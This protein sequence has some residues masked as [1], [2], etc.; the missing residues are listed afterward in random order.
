VSDEI[1]VLDRADPPPFDILGAEPS[2]PVLLV[3][4]H[5]SS[6]IPARFHNLGVSDEIMKTHCALDIGAAAVTRLLSRSLALPAVLAGYSRLVVDCNRRLDD[7][8]AFPASIDGFVIPGNQEMTHAERQ[9]RADAL[10]WPYHHAVRD[11]L[12]MLE[13][14]AKAPALV[15]IHSFVPIRNG[16]H[17]PWDIG[18]LWDVD[19]R[20]PVP[21][22]EGMRKYPEIAVGDNEPYSGKHIHDFTVDHHAE[23]EGLPHVSIELRQDLIDNDEGAGHWAELLARELRPILSDAALYTHW[24]T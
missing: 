18:V 21:L 14:L 2:M 24:T 16:R 11:Q 15:A 17:R 1:S 13:A 9:A 6:R 8:T 7:P 23:A 4:D 20:I 5:A 3:C 22:I 19:P 10:Y 12:G